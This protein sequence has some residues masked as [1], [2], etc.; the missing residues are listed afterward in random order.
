MAHP[1]SS[2]QILV[3]LLQLLSKL[4]NISEMII[5]S[6]T[7]C[8]FCTIFWSKS[9]PYFIRILIFYNC[10]SKSVW[11]ILNILNV[12]FCS[13]MLIV[14]SGVLFWS[15][16][17]FSTNDYLTTIEGI[18]ETPTPGYP[19]PI[20]TPGAGRGPRHPGRDSREQLVTPTENSGS[21]RLYRFVMVYFK[22][23]N[24]L[25][26]LFLFWSDFEICYLLVY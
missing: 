24:V 21:R 1:C 9:A 4:N 15:R 18:P 22:I 14:C 20:T 3:Q 5:N 23:T 2:L 12:F 8:N 11:F 13:I 16:F 6:T 17:L 19:T 10:Q 7:I 26:T 25:V